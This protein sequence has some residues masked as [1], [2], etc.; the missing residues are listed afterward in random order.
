MWFKYLLI[1]LFLF[2]IIGSIATIDVFVPDMT[3]ERAVAIAIID[4]LIILGI[5]V[6]WK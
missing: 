3:K 1:G 5:C 6:Y 4:L 2:N